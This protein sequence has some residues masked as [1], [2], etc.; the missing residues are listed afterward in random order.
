MLLTLVKLS[1]LPINQILNHIKLR[2]SS[3]FL[4]CHFPAIRPLIR[5]LI[6][7]LIRPQ[8]H[9]QLKAVNQSNREIARWREKPKLKPKWVQT[10]AKSGFHI[11]VC[12]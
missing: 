10:E 6:H 2:A 11:H 1:L 5:P 7:P 3:Q 12:M 8:H 4:P 9:A